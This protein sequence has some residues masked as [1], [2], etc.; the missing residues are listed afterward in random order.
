M[1][2]ADFNKLKDIVNAAPSDVSKAL[3]ESDGVMK[4]IGELP[5]TQATKVYTRRRNH[6]SE[7]GNSEGARQLD[8]LLKNLSGMA[9]T[10]VRLLSVYF[11]FGGY[12]VF[13]SSSNKI[14]GIYSLDTNTT[15]AIEFLERSKASGASYPKLYRISGGSIGEVIE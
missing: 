2:Q 4:E 6:L 13:I 8:T 15:Q 9:N 11:D 14:L 12:T 10:N 1:T 7:K 5:V 3:M